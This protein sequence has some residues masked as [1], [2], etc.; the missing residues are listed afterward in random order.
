M[1]PAPSGAHET[2]TV[3]ERV[4]RIELTDVAEQILAKR[5]L[6][7]HED[8]TQETPEDMLARVATAISDVERDVYGASEQDKLRW[9]NTFYEIMATRKFLP[10]SPTLTNAGKPGVQ[11]SACYV[12]DIPDDM[13]GIFETMKNAALIHKSGGGVGY[14]F[15]KLRPAG[16]PVGSTGGVASGPISFLEVFNAATEAVKQGGVR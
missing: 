3:G 7:K 16:D 4:Q 6:W 2:R 14:S 8:G 9:R 15:S 13:S 1:V 10:N 12:L 5:Y 11:M